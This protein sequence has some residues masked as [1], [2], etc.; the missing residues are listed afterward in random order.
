MSYVV[1]LYQDRLYNAQAQM[2]GTFTIGSGKKDSMHVDG[3]A[4]SQIIIRGNRRGENS[5]EGKA[6]SVFYDDNV[7]MDSMIML[8]REEHLALYVTE[9]TGTSPQTLK[10]AYNCVVNVGR[11]DKNHVAI[12][13]PYVS[14]RHFT[15]RS[16][17]GV[18]RVEDH[19]STNGLYLNG[20]RISKAKLH[21]GDVLSALHVNIRMVGNELFFDNV[22]DSLVIHGLEEEHA[23]GG[24]ARREDS[25]EGTLRYRRS[26]RTQEQLPSEDII[27]ASAPSG[28]SKYEK[29]KGM[30]SSFLGTGAMFAANMAMGV[31]S[32]AM[33]AARAA[34]LVSPV[35]SMVTQ[36]GSEKQ[37]K[38]KLAEY[39]QMRMEK[40]GQYIGEQK[41]RIEAVATVQREILARENPPAL[42]CLENLRQLNR[43]LWER[44]AGDRDFLDVRLGMGYE[45]LCVQVR[46]RDENAFRMESDEVRELAER[47]VEETRYVD[48]VPA[49][50]SL[51]Q[52]NTISIIG[53]RR[54]VID[55]VRNMLVSLTSAHCFE[56]VRIVGI[57]DQGEQEQWEALRWLPHVWDES[58]QF[59]FLAFDRKQAHVLCDLMADTLRGREREA[60]DGYQRQQKRPLPHYI[61]LLGSREYTEKE[62]IMQ[63]LTANEPALGATTLFLFDDL[64]SLPH[65]CQFIVDVDNGPCGYVR[66]EVNNKFF[67]TM[68]TSVTAEQFDSFARQMS[69]IELEGFTTQ[70][71]IPQ[72]LGFLQGFGVSRVEQLDALSRWKNSQ[73]Y[74]T[75]AAPLGVMGGEKIFSLDI[76]EKAHGPHGLVAGTTGSGK[77][78]LLQ[79]WILSM[80]L[81]YHPHDVV[82]VIIDYKGGGMANL[83]VELPHVVGKITNIGSNIGRSLISLQ[84]E[85]KRRQRIFDQY[86]EYQVNHIDKYQKLYRDG[87]VNEPLPH[88]II[89][90]DEF[91]E[92]KT[93]EPEFMAGLISAARIGRSL[94]V[95]LVLATQKPT[96][97][98]DEQIQSNSKFRL[99][100]KVQNA[101]DSR[102]M[103]RRPDAARITQPGRCYVL[104]GEEEVFELFQSYWSGAPYTGEAQVAQDSGNQVRIVGLTGERSKPLQKERTTVKADMDELTAIRRYLRKVAEENGI[105]KLDGPWLPELPE[106][107]SLAD[108]PDFGKGELM[109]GFDGSGWNRTL[110]WL[111]I[112]VGIYDAPA[113]QAQGIQYLDLA[114][115]GHYGIYGAPATGKTTLLKTILWALGCHYSPADVNIYI[116]DCGGWSMNVLAGMPHVGGVALD[117]EEEKFQKLGQM[118]T[119]EMNSRKRRFLQAGVSS[120]SAYRQAYAVRH[121]LEEGQAVGDGS[122]LA[123]DGENMPAIVI[124]IDNIVPVFD[125]YPDMEN[126]LVTIAREGATYGVYLIFTANNTTG[127]RYKV[128]QNI[129]GAVAFELTDKGDYPTIVGRLDG[130]SLPR[131]TGRAFYKGNPPIEFQAAMY[132]EGSDEQ[133]RSEELKRRCADMDAVWQGPR[134]AAIPVMPE[135]LSFEELFKNYHERSQVPMGITYDA[136]RPA[137]GRMTDRYCMLV[138]GTIGSGK[139]RYLCGL[140]DSIHEKRPEDKVYVFDGQKGSLKSM[141]SQVT[142]YG[143]ASDEAQVTQ[144]LEEIVEMLNVRKRAQNQARSM[145]GDT[146]SE[147]EFIAGYEQ[148]CIFIDDLKEFVDAVDN[149]NKNS[150]ERICR[151]AQGLGVLVFVAGRVS[152]I[153]RYNEIE[154]LTRAI[155]A[156]QNGVGLGGS[157]SIHTFLRNDLNYKEKEQE[158]GEGNGYFFDDGHCCKIKLPR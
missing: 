149:N 57:F 32:P 138:S 86:Q 104:V 71:D 10:L 143:M 73:P 16:E 137:I 19:D 42:E 153:E 3:M 66:N 151:L 78:E 44:G 108:L 14:G 8:S 130:R 157:A 101:G 81:H 59:R 74:K 36:S 20:K 25:G 60:G 103:I 65:S 22:G 77:S 111:R 12:H 53:G 46:S 45:K 76:H 139:S 40:Y 126:L 30:F 70:A 23:L 62:E 154:S 127:V 102:E 92:L 80:A 79:S 47:I 24:L 121:G 147:Q 15:I 125:Q 83:L 41:A 144:M 61:F 31:A 89:V 18:V 116:L 11:S 135:E 129:R 93:N 67:F 95:H 118:L 109:G 140:A 56:E 94:G 28:G 72:G 35:T 33:L 5:V 156:N 114:T 55:L 13:S 119:E 110:P 2:P 54:R 51:R 107:A 112:P 34:S 50:L 38:G 58:R 75:L 106:M 69:A 123:M 87:K 96:G 85:M 158:A 68:D 98:V 122:R 142:A 39:E 146:F 37:R 21:A 117:C 148:I 132:L 133:S 141:A 43:S 131:V 155:V 9:I 88:L 82:F 100:L 49:R 99:C 1:L 52:Y 4:Q 64:Y 7:P 17:A 97:V 115:E 48:N 91:A 26:P 63:Y 145:A 105:R 27:L 6:P 124:A 29:R 136:I 150:M 90:A 113:L 84:S 134:P 152:D 120:L 128:V